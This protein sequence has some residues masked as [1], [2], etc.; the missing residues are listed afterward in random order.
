MGEPQTTPYASGVIS[1]AAEHWKFAVH[2]QIAPNSCRSKNRLAWSPFGGK[3]VVRAGFGM[4]NDLQDALGY[5]ADQNAHSIRPIRLPL[6]RLP[7]SSFRSIPLWRP[8]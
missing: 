4:Y 6:A 2:R 8:R 3:T 1:N 7:T 5:R